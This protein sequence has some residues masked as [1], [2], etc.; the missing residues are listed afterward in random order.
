MGEITRNKGFVVNENGEIVRNR[1][2]PKCGRSLFSEGGYCEYCGAKINGGRG[3]LFVWSCL[4]IVFVIGG[5]VWALLKLNDGTVGS[6]SSY[7]RERVENT[8]NTFNNA[9][10]SNDFSTL[11]NVFSQNV[12]RFNDAYN[13]SNS[14]VVEKHKKYDSMFGVYGKHISVRWN[15]LQ[16]EKNLED[17]LSVFYVEDYSI[18]RVDESKYSVFVIEKHLILDNEYRIKSI[19][20]MQLSK[21]RK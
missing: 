19:Y 4:A 11:S 20:D 16:I 1:K 15:T 3:H 14:E 21:A 17:E 5:T 13:L 6:S 10:E 18:D 8:I 7:E 2:C 12:T 9:V